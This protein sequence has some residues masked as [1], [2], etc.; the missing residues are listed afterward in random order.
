MLEYIQQVYEVYSTKQSAIDYQALS[1]ASTR[2]THTAYDI[3]YNKR[4]ILSTFE[5]IEIFADNLT[6]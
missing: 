1:L 5:Q 2:C 6:I 4:Y 3:Q